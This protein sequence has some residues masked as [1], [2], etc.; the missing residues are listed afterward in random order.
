[1]NP[2][3][4]GGGTSPNHPYGGHAH[5]LS[6]TPNPNNPV[7]QGQA[8]GTST[9]TGTNAGTR[10]ASAPT[11]VGYN[12]S[13]NNSNSSI[14]SSLNGSQ[15]NLAH[16]GPPSTTPPAHRAQL[17]QSSASQSLQPQ[18]PPTPGGSAGNP[19]SYSPMYTIESTVTRLLV[20]TKQLLE[21]IT[22]WSHG[23]ATEQ[24]VSDV[25][26]N[27]GNEFNVACRAF[28]SS[29]VDVA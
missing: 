11:Q 4:L 10:S 23:E 9:G 14:G 17:H 21:S 5:S 25:Y 28:L 19:R 13:N 26:V 18:Y 16:R 24:D 22:Q 12:S 2:S 27:L 7:G 15:S 20:A 29:G 8:P 1:M 3:S 6:S